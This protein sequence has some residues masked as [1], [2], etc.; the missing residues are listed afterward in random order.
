ML[1]H[2]E[3]RDDPRFAT[4]ADRMTN[5]DAL[6]EKMNAVLGTRSKAEWIEA[7]D[8]A[9]VPAGPVHSHRRGADASAD[10]RARHGRRSRPPAGRATKALGC[11][12]HFSATP[13]AITRPAPRL[14]EHTR[15]L[16]REYGYSDLEI[17]GLIADGVAEAAE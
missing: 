14:G 2:P 9:G 3:W 12:V 1:G 8:A 13:T 16:L 6:V 17:D 4:N 11:P 15:N 5:L 10:A 7:F